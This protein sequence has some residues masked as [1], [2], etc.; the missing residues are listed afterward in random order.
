MGRR[1]Q[2]DSRR[3]VASGYGVVG[4]LRSAMARTVEFF[5]AQSSMLILGG[6]TI[7]AEPQGDVIAAQ[8]PV[9]FHAP[10]SGWSRDTYQ[11]A[12]REVIRVRGHAPQTVTLHPE[13]LGAV[14]RTKL[15][16]EVE[17][18]A[19]MVQAAVRHEEQVLQP[20]LER[21]KDG[22]RIVTSRDHDR[23]HDRDGVAG[24]P[25]L[26]DAMGCRSDR[27]CSGWVAAVPLACSLDSGGRCPFGAVPGVPTRRS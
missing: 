24:E 1:V 17:K 23:R 9:V 27:G 25:D 7:V 18:T 20:V 5:F 26:T 14:M 15:L 19:E 11:G 3:G 16:E 2:R 8:G 22:F 21:A 13:T 10:A 4:F 6:G 12:I